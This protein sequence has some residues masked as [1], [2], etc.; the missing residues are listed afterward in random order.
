[1]CLSEGALPEGDAAKKTTQA[2][3]GKKQNLNGGK[4]KESKRTKNKL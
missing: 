2:I 4:Q 1:L 3:Q